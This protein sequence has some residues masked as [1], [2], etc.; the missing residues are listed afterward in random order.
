[1]RNA[2]L[3]NEQVGEAFVDY[4]SKNIT[5]L[6]YDDAAIALRTLAE[7]KF[8]KTALEKKIESWSQ[9]EEFF[10]TAV[11][12]NNKMLL[13]SNLSFVEAFWSKEFLKF[14]VEKTLARMESEMKMDFY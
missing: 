2:K 10:T 12:A 7:F 5:K 8:L 1:M 13:L 14:L 9:I 3:V 4:I 11:R 6:H